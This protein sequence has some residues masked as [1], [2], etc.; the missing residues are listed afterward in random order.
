MKQY[1]QK[2]WRVESETEWFKG[3]EA[4]FP[5]EIPHRLIRMYSFA[6]DTVLDPFAGSGTTIRAA[7]N[8]ERNSIGYEINE[9]LIPVIKRRLD[10]GQTLLI[11]REAQIEISFAQYRIR[12]SME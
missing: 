3:H 12:E 6:G 9:D 11:E 10:I 7:M 2:I 1:V 8:L 5:E 4:V